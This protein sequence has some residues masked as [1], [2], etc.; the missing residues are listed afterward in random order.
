M[1]RGLGAD[2]F[3]GLI[4]STALH[5][6]DFMYRVLLPGVSL[7]HS[8]LN[9]QLGCRYSRPVYPPAI[10]SACLSQDEWSM[11]RIL[12]HSPLEPAFK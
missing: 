4:V 8:F 10:G 6:Q 7:P 9:T 5:S 1:P 3:W 12:R 2:S 11:H